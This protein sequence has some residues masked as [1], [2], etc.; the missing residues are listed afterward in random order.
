MQITFL[1]LQIVITNFSCNPFRLNCVLLS[2]NLD[3]T[4]YFLKPLAAV[5]TYVIPPWQGSVL[6]AKDNRC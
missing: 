6:G 1:V 3:F 4:A 2:P 5:F